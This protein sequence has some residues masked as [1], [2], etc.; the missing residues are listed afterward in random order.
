MVTHTVAVLRLWPAAKA[1]GMSASAIAT[2]GFGMSASWQSRSIIACS[3]G[4]SSGSVTRALIAASA[5]LSPK[6]IC[7]RAKP[8]A[9]RRIRIAPTPAAIST[10]MKTT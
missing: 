8:P 9:I 6:R 3:S 10:A 5:I 4:A 2:L 7:T 1:L